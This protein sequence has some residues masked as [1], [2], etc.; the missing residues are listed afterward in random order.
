MKRLVALFFLLIYSFTTIGATVHSH[1]C[2][3]QY[4]GSSLFHSK[5]SKCPKC[6]M[7]TSKAK[8]GCCQD[9]DTQLKIKDDHS[10][11][12]APQLI[13]SIFTD[14]VLPIQIDKY[15]FVF[16]TTYVKTNTYSHSPP[17]IDKQK[18]YLLYRVFLI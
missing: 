4:M 7:K 15:E 11:A 13:Y 3:G 18:S 2:M 8:K 9:K 6:G 16:L 14:C 10:K 5:D 12:K 1:Y 17:K